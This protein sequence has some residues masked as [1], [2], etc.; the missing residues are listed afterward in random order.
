MNLK[1]RLLTK[2]KY[3]QI[4]HLVV[5]LLTTIRLQV[6]RCS[7]TSISQHRRVSLLVEILSSLFLQ[8]HFQAALPIGGEYERKILMV[9]VPIVSGQPQTASQ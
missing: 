9:L 3:Q 7:Q 4:M 8:L 5:Q 2:S 1:M 6:L